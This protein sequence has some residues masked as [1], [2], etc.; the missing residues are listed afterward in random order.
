VLSVALQKG[1]SF[2][3]APITWKNDFRGNDR[4]EK[5]M[6]MN[7]IISTMETKLI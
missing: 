4:V 6:L 2:N 1:A 5:S 7:I 3:S